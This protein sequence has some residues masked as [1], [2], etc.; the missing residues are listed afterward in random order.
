M[1]N[2]PG[3][4]ALLNHRPPVGDPAAAAVEAD[5]QYAQIQTPG[6]GEFLWSNALCLFPANG[7]VAADAPRRPSPVSDRLAS[8]FEMRPRLV[9]INAAVRAQN[10]SLLKLLPIST[11]NLGGGTIAASITEDTAQKLSLLVWPNAMQASPANG[12]FDMT[13]GLPGKARVTVYDDTAHYRVAPGSSHTVTVSELA[14]PAAPA[15]AKKLAAPPAPRVETLIA[16]ANGILK[17]ELSSSAA[18]VEIEPAP[19]MPLA[20]VTVRQ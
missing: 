5:W 10:L 17:V 6:A 13:I 4:I 9:E 8:E 14:A 15:G 19:A 7:E 3:E 1:I 16:D 11:Q 20:P 12:T 2:Y 18:L